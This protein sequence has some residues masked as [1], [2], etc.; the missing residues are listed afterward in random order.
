ML[1]S[2]VSRTGSPEQLRAQ[3]ASNYRIA[4]ES[5]TTNALGNREEVLL[6]WRND[7]L[8]YNMT[9]KE[10]VVTDIGVG[11]RGLSAA[12]VIACLGQPTHYSATYGYETEGGTQ[13][14]LSMLFP[15]QGVLIGGARILSTRPKQPPAIAGDFPM[16]DLLFMPPGSVDTLLQRVHGV[17]VPFLREQMIGTYKPWFGDWRGIEV[18]Q[19]PTISP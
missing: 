7:G 15:D 4:V 8:W 19:Y 14:N 2:L 5:I 17:Y 3:I 11:A 1:R 16:T 10:G 18:S 13:L 6:E 9:M 12:S